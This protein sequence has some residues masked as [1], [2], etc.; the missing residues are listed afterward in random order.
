MDKA[1]GGAALLL[2][3]GTV[4]Y[5]FR[6]HEWIRQHR[7]DAHTTLIAAVDLLVLTRARLLSIPLALGETM[8]PANPTILSPPGHEPRISEEQVNQ[9]AEE[10]DEAY[11]AYRQAVAQ[12]RIVQSSRMVEPLDELDNWIKREIL[13]LMPYGKH[14]PTGG[15]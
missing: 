6:S 3:G 8:D 2:I 13:P 4:G 1:L 7:L 15:L 11:R 5:L 14:F 12:R 9:R 10:S